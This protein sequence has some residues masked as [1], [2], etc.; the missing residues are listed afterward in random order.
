MINVDVPPTFKASKKVLNHRVTDGLL[1]PVQLEIL[2]GHIGAV[3]CT[4]NKRMIPRLDKHN[5]HDRVIY[6]DSASQMFTLST[7]NSIND[8]LKISDLLISDTSSAVSEFLLLDKPVIT[9]NSHSEYIKWLD[10]SNPDVLVPETNNLFK[11]GD[12]YKLQRREVI[13]L[14]HPYPNGGSAKRMVDAILAYIKKYCVPEKRK[15]SLARKFR[16]IKKYG[17]P[18]LLMS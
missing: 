3:R 18:P 4:V 17:L 14:Y 1:T 5:S 8:L 12:A 11:K 10:I 15:V 16:I 9:L 7:D 2:L 13:D 6:Q